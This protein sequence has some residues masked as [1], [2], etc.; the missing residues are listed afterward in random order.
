MTLVHMLARADVAPW[1]APAARA[2]VF[3]AVGATLI[4]VGALRRRAR[5]RWDREDDGRLL[6]PD[7]PEASNDHRIPRPRSGGTWLIAGGT[8]LLILG[9]LHILDLVATLHVAGVI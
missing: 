8:A 1:T 5:M 4:V 9:L 3:L 2:V 6:H 7:R